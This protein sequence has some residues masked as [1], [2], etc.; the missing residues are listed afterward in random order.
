MASHKSRT[1]LVYDNGLFVELAITLSKDFGRVLYYSPWESGYPRSNALRIGEGIKG[2]ERVSSIWP[3]VDEVDLFV[4]PDVYGGALQQHLTDMGK[5]KFPKGAML[6]VEVKDKCYVGKTMRYAALPEEVRAVNE[7][8]ASTLKQYR[9][10]GFISLELRSTPDGKAY[11]IDPCAR[12]GSPP[13]GGNHHARNCCPE[14]SPW[15]RARAA[16][17]G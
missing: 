5:G 13:K 16:R 14:T 4:F 9:Y 2:V 17:A 15:R 3:H 11:L 8:L 12:R 7:K 10:R 6:G 1:V